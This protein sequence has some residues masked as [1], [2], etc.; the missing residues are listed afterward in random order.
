MAITIVDFP[1]PNKTVTI[2]W[3]SKFPFRVEVTVQWPF[4]VEFQGHTFYQTGKEGTNPYDGC[5][6]A[7]YRRQENNE[8]RRVWLSLAGTLVPD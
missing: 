4:T 8:D 5:P 1:G 6:A 7:E 2:P 3:E